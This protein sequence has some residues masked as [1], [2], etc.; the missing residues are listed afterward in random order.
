MSDSLIRPRHNIGADPATTAGK[1]RALGATII[2]V[3]IPGVNGMLQPTDIAELWSISGWIGVLGCVLVS[4]RV[5][6]LVYT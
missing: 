2:S 1:I 3:G 6:F 5:Y 4:N